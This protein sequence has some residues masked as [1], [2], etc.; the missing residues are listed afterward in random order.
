MKV[1]SSFILFFM[2]FSLYASSTNQPPCLDEVHESLKDPTDKYL[3]KAHP[4]LYG[5]INCSQPHYG[6]SI[7][8][9]EAVHLED[10]GIPH[11]A[12]IQEIEVWHRQGK[13]FPFQLF[14][15]DGLKHQEMQIEDAPKPQTLVLN[16]LSKY[17]PTVLEDPDHEMQYYVDYLNDPQ[18][19]ASYDFTKGLVTEFNAY[20]H[21]VRFESRIHPKY[22]VGQINGLFAFALFFKAYIHEAK[23]D[24]DLWKKLL[25]DSN[26]KQLRFLFDQVSHVLKISNHCKF[27][28]ETTKEFLDLL[29]EERT[30]APLSEILSESKIMKQILCK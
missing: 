1:F 30:M 12:T 17:H 22:R 25:S 8:L 16:F 29:G 9:H 6:L 19:I 13:I 3:L 10:K 2:T 27:I 24:T 14:D 5:F 11:K 18:T 20:T 28:D 26:R 4:A 7:F 21:G 23:S 15:I